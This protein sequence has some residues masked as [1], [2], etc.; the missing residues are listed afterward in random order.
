[1]YLEKYV[2]KVANVKR[3]ISKA[4]RIISKISK[5]IIIKRT[6]KIKKKAN[7][8]YNI[9]FIVQLSS[10]WDK[11]IDIYEEMLKRNNIKTFL[12]V[13]PEYDFKNDVVKKS[14]N[15]NYFIKKYK[16]CIK[17]LD[18]QGK[19]LDLRKFKLDYIFYPRPYDHYLP[20]QYQSRKVCRYCK[21]CYIPYGLTGSDNFDD[22]GYPFFDNI[23]FLFMDSDYQ[24][25]LIKSRYPVSYALG[26]KKIYSYGYPVL[27]RF[28]GYSNNNEI[29]VI[30][31]T[32]R[33]SMD[34]IKGGSNFLKYC[35]DF[36][37]MIEDHNY[38]FIFRPHPLMFDELIKK[39]YINEKFRKNF[40]EKLSNNGVLFDTVSPIEDI[41][42][43]TDLLITDFSSIIPQFFMTNRPLIYC[44]GGIPLN[45][46][47]LEIMDYS[48]SAKSWSDVLKYIKQIEE[49]DVYAK[50]RKKYVREKY[51]ICQNSARLITDELVNGDK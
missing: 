22:T 23:H 6:I 43:K 21:C 16:E 25:E 7:M 33:W 18:D 12:F 29:K 11:Q 50:Q 37:K 47:Y 2:D 4:K 46:D 34:P 1:M 13:V 40:I 30:T 44:E 15:N 5:F 10:I 17:V 36:L 41:F 24:K 51:S 20:E 48:Y 38:S 31:W 14:Y 27:S 9:G 3:I 32:P 26:I 49:E 28:L 39:G 8:P 45:K 35:D 42:K 19:W